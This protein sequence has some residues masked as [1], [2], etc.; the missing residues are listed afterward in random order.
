M[1]KK[2]KI[3][4]AI[5]KYK[6][7]YNPNYMAKQSQKMRKKALAKQKKQEQKRRIIEKQDDRRRAVHHKYK[8]KRWHDEGYPWWDNGWIQSGYYQEGCHKFYGPIYRK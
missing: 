5:K 8:C 6:K 4:K 3:R 7:G 1:V 2:G